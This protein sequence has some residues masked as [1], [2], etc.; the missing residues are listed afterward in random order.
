MRINRE[1]AIKSQ[2]FTLDSIQIF[3]FVH[4]FLLKKM[5]INP[6]IYINLFVANRSV[7]IDASEPK[8]LTTG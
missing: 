6:D 8:L 7:H 4:L 5:T 1:K 3:T 2:L